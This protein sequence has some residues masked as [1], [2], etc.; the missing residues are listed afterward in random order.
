MRFTPVGHPLKTLAIAL[1]G[2]ALGAFGLTL[3]L[4]TGAR[5][6]EITLGIEV[7]TLGLLIALWAILRSRQ[8][9]ELDLQRGSWRFAY[10]SAV[11]ALEELR[12]TPDEIAEVRI[13]QDV[14]GR[15]SHLEV[16]FVVGD[17]IDIGQGFGLSANTLAGLQGLFGA[18]HH[19]TAATA[20]R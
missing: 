10:G 9:F 12:F 16:W 7:G 6:R 4:R 20:G 14:F 2:I 8:W 15:A 3:L 5:A 1:G 19:A 11:R 17:R 13:A 18:V